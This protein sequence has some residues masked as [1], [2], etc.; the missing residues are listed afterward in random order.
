MRKF[1]L[2]I[3]T[4]ISLAAPLAGA[5]LAQTSTSKPVAVN[6]DP[7]AE[8]LRNLLQP[9]SITLDETRL[10]DVLKFVEQV[11][12]VYLDIAWLDNGAS[13]GLERDALITLE[14]RR[15]TLMDFLERVL[16]KASDE[17]DA[18]TWQLDEAG[19]IEV[20]PRSALNRRKS[21]QIYPISDLTF[22]I[23]NF[24]SVPDLDL[25]SVLQQTGNRGG[26]TQ[27]IF[28]DPNDADPTGGLSE[29]EQA[30]RIVDL[31][32]GLIE[33]EQWERNGGSGAS[34]R[35][36]N[37]SMLIKAPDYIHRQI[38][39]YPFAAG[40]MRPSQGSPAGRYVTLSGSF[41]NSQFVETRQVPVSG[42]TGNAPAQQP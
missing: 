1:T 6:A 41:E 39:G 33:T 25:D 38:G 17:F 22:T 2:A 42:G 27:S 37:G 26:G 31:V 36:L 3:V 16:D 32:T 12:N 29:E 7:R 34:V 20:G 40:A 9:V 5:A 23:P 28:N 15:M 8:T 18:A 4:G 10:E 19:T 24:T 21:L 11:G 30:E 35:L 14:A 13:S